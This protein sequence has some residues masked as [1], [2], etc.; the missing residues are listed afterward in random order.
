MADIICRSPANR[1]S[2]NT[3][4]IMLLSQSLPELTGISM[5]CRVQAHC[6]AMPETDS[7]EA[8]HHHSASSEKP[9]RHTSNIAS[10]KTLPCCI[11]GEADGIF[12][13]FTRPTCIELKLA[14]IICS[15]ALANAIASPASLASSMIS[16]AAYLSMA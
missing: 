9:A 10:A 2:C 3:M 1:C 8:R 4:A 11:C 16:R 6:Y 15:P 13:H 5:K 14:I 7:D 12:H